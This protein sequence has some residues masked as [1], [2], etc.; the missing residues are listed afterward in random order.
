MNLLS[1]IGLLLIPFLLCGVYHLLQWPVWLHSLYESTG[2]IA[3]AHLFLPSSS[4]EGLAGM[5]YISLTTGLNFAMVKFEAFRK[6]VDEF[7]AQWKLEVD[8]L[9]AKKCPA[10]KADDEFRNALNAEIETHCREVALFIAVVGSIA[11]FLQL[12]LGFLGVFLFFAVAGSSFG[13]WNCKRKFRNEVEPVINFQADVLERKQPKLK[14][15]VD[16][17]IH[18]AAPSGPRK[19]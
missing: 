13:R 6:T 15:E 8:E 7:E 3:L 2:T 1:R 18:N 19:G 17:V 11:L 12:S 9:I 5:S 4:H 14:S 16:E 10:G